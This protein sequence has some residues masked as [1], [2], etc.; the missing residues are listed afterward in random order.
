[1]NNFMKE[2]IVCLVLPNNT[3]GGMERV[4]IEIA[5]YLSLIDNIQVHLVLYENDN[6]YFIDKKVIIHLP[7]KKKTKRKILLLF[8][9]FWYLRNTFKKVKPYS[10][11]SFGET[12][13]SF[14]ILSNWGLGNR[15]FVSDRS[16]PDKDWGRFHNLLRKF[17]Y[18]M[19]TGIIAQT[20]YAATFIC[21][22]IKKTNI[23]VIGNPIRTIKTENINREHVI[24]YVGRLIKSKRVDLLL[25]Y[26]S[27]CQYGDW[28]LLIVGDGDEVE[29]L[30][31]IAETLGI[32]KAVSFEGKQSNV[33]YYYNRSSI[34][35]FT[36]ISEGFPNV[37]GEALSAGIPCVSFDCIAGPS[38]L[39]K[40]GENGFLIPVEDENTFVEKLNLLISD[41]KLRDKMSVKAKEISVANSN[42]TIC[43][44]FK[45]ILIE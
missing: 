31:E 40:D 3:C 26:F 43:Q 19:A 33:D 7:S 5:N 2:T 39:I 28:K 27:K 37:L 12:Y 11:L 23:F 13:N 24:L 1:M 16:R 25:R 8:K 18:K 45:K 30:K 10:I 29:V 21:N 20:N 41:K 34:F 17:T 4:M 32:S 22:E 35:A 44:L 6:F 36:S 38:D 42:S 9:Y 15:I 14:C